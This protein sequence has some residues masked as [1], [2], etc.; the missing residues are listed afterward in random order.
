MAYPH[1]PFTIRMGEKG[2]RSDLASTE[3][4][5]LTKLDDTF[6]HSSHIQLLLKE[7]KSESDLVFVQ[8]FLK[9]SQKIL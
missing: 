7:G 4:Y 5:S 9:E 3:V 2:A 8:S 6:H 1:P